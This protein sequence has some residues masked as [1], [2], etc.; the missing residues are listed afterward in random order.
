MVYLT[1]NYCGCSLKCTCHRLGTFFGGSL[2]YTAV[3]RGSVAEMARASLEDDPN[4]P[5][6]VL[7]R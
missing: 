4:A 5:T 7:K 6:N 3:P 2:F 1:S